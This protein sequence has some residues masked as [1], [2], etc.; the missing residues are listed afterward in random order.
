MAVV[1][2]MC[3]YPAMVE[4]GVEI[5][6]AEVLM[7]AVDATCRCPVMEVVDW[8]LVGEIL[9]VASGGALMDK[10]ARRAVLV[11]RTMAVMMVRLFVMD[12]E[13][14]AAL[15]YLTGIRQELAVIHRTQ[16]TVLAVTLL[17][18]RG[19]ACRRAVH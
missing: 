16:L 11:I 5:S 12:M 10:V 8:V 9:V 17:M 15:E 7:V 2:A 18:Y 13:L 3:R 19:L 6:G 4:A 14:A 1:D